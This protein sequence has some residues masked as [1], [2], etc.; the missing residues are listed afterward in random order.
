MA[1]EAV[2]LAK[3]ILATDERRDS[4]VGAINKRTEI[5]QP[6]WPELVAGELPIEGGASTCPPIFGV[7]LEDRIFE[8]FFAPRSEIGKVSGNHPFAVFRTNDLYPETKKNISVY[9][10]WRFFADRSAAL[11]MFKLWIANQLD[12][13]EVKKAM[14]LEVEVEVV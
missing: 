13:A 6:H 11:D 7:E 12:L 3:A 2:A 9:V 4:I 14:S 10:D 5:Y 8:I 1:D